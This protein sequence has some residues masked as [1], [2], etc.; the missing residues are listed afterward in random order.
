MNNITTNQQMIGGKHMD[1]D[2]IREF[3]LAVHCSPDITPQYQEACQTGDWKSY[4]NFL[5][6]LIMFGIDMETLESLGGGS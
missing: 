5:E 6:D 2:E 1:A 4:A 3:L